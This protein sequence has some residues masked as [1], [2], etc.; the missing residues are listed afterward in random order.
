MYNDPRLEMEL[1]KLP[2][3]A[4][5]ITRYGGLRK[6]LL[7]SSDFYVLEDHVSLAKDQL[8][9]R[10]MF[11]DRNSRL[12]EAGLPP[13]PITGLGFGAPAGN[14]IVL[15]PPVGAGNLHVPPMATVFPGVTSNP[16][17]SNGVG[18]V[19]ALDSFDVPAAG[20]AK[21]NN[22]D[23]INLQ[24]SVGNAESKTGVVVA[25]AADLNSG[26]DMDKERDR[27]LEAQ[28]LNSNSLQSLNHGEPFSTKTSNSPHGLGVKSVSVD[29]SSLPSFD[30]G[31][32]SLPQ[33]NITSENKKSL[34]NDTGG[35]S[36]NA[37]V[38]SAANNKN[39]RKELPTTNGGQTLGT[40]AT[41]H[42]DVTQSEHPTPVVSSETESKSDV[43]VS[44]KEISDD[45]GVV[46]DFADGMD[47]S[48][49]KKVPTI[50][51]AGK[52]HDKDDKSD[53]APSVDSVER[54]SPM[55]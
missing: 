34:Q 4:P 9:C 18:S 14:N 51:T 12:Q 16:G 37:D 44:V 33:S 19:A 26:H 28:Q 43:S 8:K 24:R 30:S 7:Q 39:C 50:E 53:S 55:V 46:K 35:T 52:V 49:E 27:M 5:V 15:N 48:A 3:A 42:S 45:K 10:Q 47:S 2:E 20:G 29:I 23:D 41:T 54:K 31:L 13:P 25:A 22:I 21:M 1:D 38:T 17:G 6:F 11:T 36:Q 40:T 32:G